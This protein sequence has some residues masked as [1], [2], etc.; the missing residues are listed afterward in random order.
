[1]AKNKYPGLYWDKETGKGAVDKRIE[2]LGRVRHR[3]TAGTCVMKRK[4]NTTMQQRLRL[5]H[6]S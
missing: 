2:G 1:M 4:R 3:F 6:Q 5:F